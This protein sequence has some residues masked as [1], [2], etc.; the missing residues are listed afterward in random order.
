MKGNSTTRRLAAFGFVALLAAGL[1]WGLVGAFAASASPSPGTGKVDPADRLDERA[2]QPQPVHRLPRDLRDLGAQLHVL[3]G[4]GDH[5]QPT[6]DLAAQFPTQANGGISADGKVWTDPPAARRQMAGRRA[7]DRRRRRLHLHL[8][9]Q[10]P[11]GEHHQLTTVI[12]TGA[13]PSTRPPCGSSA[14]RPRPT[15]RSSAVPI[16]PEHIWE[17]VSPQAA[18]TS[19]VNKPPI[20][21]SGPFQT[22]AFIKGS[23]VEMVRNP[24]YWGKKPAIDQIYFEL[25]QDADTMVSDLKTGS[26]DA[27]WGM[28]EAEF[29][30][31]RVA[32]R[33]LQ[34][35]RLQ[36]LQLG[37]PRVQLLRQVEL[38][39]QPRAARLEVPQR[40]ELRDQPQQLCAVAYSGLAAPATT[41][42]PPEHLAEPRLPLAAAGRPALHLRPRQGQPAPHARPA[43]R[44]ENGVRLNRQGKPITLRLC[45]HDRQPC[46]PDRRQADRRLAASKLGLKIKLSVVDAGALRPAS[47]THTATPGRP[48]STCTCGTGRATSTPARRSAVSPRHEIGSLNEPFWSN[49]QYDALDA[50]AGGGLDPQARQT[51]SGRCSRSCTSRRPGWCSPTRSTSRLT[52]PR[53]GPAG[54]R[55]STAAGRPSWRPA[56]CSRE[57]TP[58]STC[59][60]RLTRPLAAGVRQHVTI[61]IAIVVVSRGS[62]VWLVRRGRVRVEEA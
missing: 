2:R 59:D 41:I 36:L 15:S 16:L 61:V 23:Y 18:G 37:L 53:S 8:H 60:R 39:G 48:T 11:H 51:P 56:A 27:A 12:M 6:L 10:E 45:D 50:V 24:Y 34:G 57:S 31:A 7:A 1:V 17:H 58:T 42:I 3:F 47:T 26:I 21:G 40:P 55:C 19:Y 52:T 44:S 28:P 30:A 22:V 54:P 4:Y 29:T 20:I 32:A 35:G 13:R 49:A 5:N 46:G 38:A 43:T 25:Y 14:R 62:R 9:H 33:H